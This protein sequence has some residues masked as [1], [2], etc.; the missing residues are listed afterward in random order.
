VSFLNLTRAQLPL[1]PSKEFLIIDRL[2]KGVLDESISAIILLHAVWSA[3]SVKCLNE[4]S[5]AFDD[6]DSLKQVKFKI[7]NLDNLEVSFLQELP[8]NVGGNGE[9]FF[10]VDGKIAHSIPHF[11]DD[12]LEQLIKYYI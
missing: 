10:I 1:I 7:L 5:K 3:P 12:F 6:C 9:T 8:I 2:K 11:A 4:Y